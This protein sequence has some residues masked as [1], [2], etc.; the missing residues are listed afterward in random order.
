V[1]QKPNF[2]AH[3]VEIALVLRFAGGLISL[4]AP[5]TLEA[6]CAPAAE[7]VVREIAG[8]VLI[9]PL[10]AGIVEVEGEL[11]TLNPTGRAM[12]QKLDGL[13]TLKEVAALLANE[14]AAPQ[15]T[16]ENDV[17]RFAEELRLKKLAVVQNQV[18]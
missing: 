2:H 14:F 10:V 17:V 16:I 15:I 11:F 4:D 12:W 7:V 1:S 18:G 8:N 5:V 13:R 9:I 6:I 3:K